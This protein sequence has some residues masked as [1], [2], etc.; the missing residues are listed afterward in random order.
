MLKSVLVNGR[1]TCGPFIVRPSLSFFSSAA[2]ASSAVTPSWS[3]SDSSGPTLARALSRAIRSRDS[4]A[5][6]T[7]DDSLSESSSG[8]APSP[9]SCTLTA[10]T[11][12]DAINFCINA[13]PSSASSNTTDE[14]AGCPS[15]FASCFPLSF[16]FSFSFEGLEHCAAWCPAS[17]QFQHVPLGAES[18]FRP[19][20]PFLSPL[21]NFLPF[22]P[23]VFFLSC[24]QRPKW[25][26]PHVGQVFFGAAP[27]A[28]LACPVGPPCIAF[29]ILYSATFLSS[30]S[31]NFM[32]SFVVS[33]VCHVVNTCVSS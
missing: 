4:L 16:A 2:C 23:G 17:W 22:P 11:C 33:I 26:L 8:A 18:P 32:G 31:T 9:P 29:F 13:R 27:K 24:Q 20:P 3:S 28:K 15:F 10:P 25:V 19:P 6:P 14:P 30:K 12:N 7:P 5:T 1:K 21:P